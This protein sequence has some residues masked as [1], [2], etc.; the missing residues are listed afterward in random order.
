LTGLTGFTG[1][2]HEGTKK[3][4]GLTTDYTGLRQGYGLAGRLTRIHSTLLRTGYLATETG[5]NA[6]RESHAACGRSSVQNRAD[7]SPQAPV[8]PPDSV[9]PAISCQGDSCAVLSFGVLL[10]GGRWGLFKEVY[11]YTG[12]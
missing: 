6:E 8:H 7:C 4:E 9:Q 2:H 10:E 3:H 12:M 1:F 5:E 11:R